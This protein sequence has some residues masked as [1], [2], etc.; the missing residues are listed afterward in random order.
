M[1]AAVGDL[2]G[3]VDAAP[4]RRIALAVQGELR[5]LVSGVGVAS[6][7]DMLPVGRRLPMAR[8]CFMPGSLPQ[9]L[10]CRDICQ[11]GHLPDRQFKHHRMD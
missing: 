7:R 3:R 5:L 1:D 9:A 6:S 4:T 2:L 8:F 10:Q 11:Y